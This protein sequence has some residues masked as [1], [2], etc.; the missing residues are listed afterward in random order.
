MLWISTI[1]KSNQTR[2]TKYMDTSRSTDTKVGSAK[3]PL[4]IKFIIGVGSILLVLLILTILGFTLT[5]RYVIGSGTAKSVTRPVAR[6]TQVALVGQG[7]LIVQQ[8][9]AE[10]LRIEADDNILPFITSEVSDGRLTLSTNLNRPF[11]FFLLR[12]P[13]KYVLTVK[14]LSK[15]NITGS[16]SVAIDS[17]STSQLTLAIDGS[18]SATLSHLS[19]TTFLANIAGSGDMTLSG[20]AQQQVITIDGS[21]S[22]HGANLA[23]DQANITINGS[24]NVSVSVMSMLTIHIA[25][26][27]DVRYCGNPTIEQDVSG[28]GSIGR[29]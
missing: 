10:S 28:S 21:G 15:V 14:D 19:A 26:S 20:Q 7:S 5:G 18:G 25:G 17:L 22:Y 27:G 3:P 24:G 9:G 2:R 29:C 11:N 4:V 8:T 16:G 12:T 6:F 13:I 1:I 23:S